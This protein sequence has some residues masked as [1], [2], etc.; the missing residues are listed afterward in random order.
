MEGGGGGGGM[1]NRC[2]FTVVYCQDDEGRGLGE[3]L[4][5]YCGVLPG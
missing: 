1:V 5:L 2:F 3:S 4:L